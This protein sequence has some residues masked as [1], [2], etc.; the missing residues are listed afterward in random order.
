MIDL[1]YKCDIA[2]LIN[3]GDGSVSSSYDIPIYF[4]MEE[5]KSPCMKT[6]HLIL[7]R[8]FEVEQIGVRRNL[9]LILKLKFK[10]IISISLN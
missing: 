10:L 2:Y 4:F 8:Q 6:K 7:R 3:R 9:F 1:Y 5:N